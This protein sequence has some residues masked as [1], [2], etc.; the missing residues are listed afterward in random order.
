MVASLALS[1]LDCLASVG[2]WLCGGVRS[3]RA[4]RDSHHGRRMPMADKLAMV[5]R[6]RLHWTGN[7]FL[8]RLAN[9]GIPVQSGFLVS[10][11]RTSLASVGGSGGA[12]RL[13]L[14]APRHAG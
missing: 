14:L 13:L 11:T 8:G 9:R 12:V 6:H 4:D 3:L 5:V 1:I 10:A 7:F 2:D